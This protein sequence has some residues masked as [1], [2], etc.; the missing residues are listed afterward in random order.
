MSGR[1]V[2]I[3]KV[4]D[5]YQVDTNA[6]PSE[7]VPVP[8]SFT[9][10]ISQGSSSVR[11]F[12]FDQTPD[13]ISGYVEAVCEYTSA[14]DEVVGCSLEYVSGS[15]TKVSDTEFTLDGTTYEIYE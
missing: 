2:E 6:S 11:L 7:G 12:N 9:A 5:G 10:W 15:Y 8:F 4:G 3:T 13:D 14:L 1:F